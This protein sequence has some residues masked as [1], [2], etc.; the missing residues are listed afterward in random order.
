MEVWRCVYVFNSLYHI[1]NEK[2]DNQFSKYWAI[3]EAFRVSG[4]KDA[5]LAESITSQFSVFPGGASL[6]YEQMLPYWQSWAEN[7]KKQGTNP[8]ESLIQVHLNE[9]NRLQAEQDEK[10]RLAFEK[11]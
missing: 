8:I 9:A 6:G 10:D 5:E 2:H 7:T 4:N 11:L 1:S 3:E